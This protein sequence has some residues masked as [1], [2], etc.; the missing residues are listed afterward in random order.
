[1]EFVSAADKTGVQLRPKV[2]IALVVPLGRGA[3]DASGAYYS[4]YQDSGS[5]Q[6][7]VFQDGGVTQGTWVKA[8][9]NEQFQFTDANGAPIELDA[10]QTWITLV[11]SASQVSY[12]P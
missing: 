6:M 5:G 7:Y 9:T 3:L 2:V 12:T 1:M 4:D 11:S 8:G 10:G